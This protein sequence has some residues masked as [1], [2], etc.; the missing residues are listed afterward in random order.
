MDIIRLYQDYTIDFV[1]EGHKHARPGWVNVECPWCTGN[2]GYHLGYEL[3]K[4]YYYCWR[5]GWH[6][7]VPTVSRLLKIREAEGRELV[8]L[9]GLLIAKRIE[10]PAIKSKKEFQLP[11]YVDVLRESHKR[12]LESRGYDPE[13]LEQIWNLMSTSPLSTLDGISYRNRILIPFLWN[14]KMVSFDTRVTSNRLPH[15][16][17]YKA[18]PKSRE[19]IEHKHIL[20]GRQEEWRETGIC[21][22][23]P[24]DVWRLGTAS[25]ATSGIQYT[26]EQLIVM[27]RTF[28]RIFVMYDNEPQAQAQA[29]KLVADLNFR[30]VESAIVKI[31]TNDPG[32]L[33]QSD[34]DY[35]VKQLL[36]FS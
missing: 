25:F 15:E 34:A 7:I 17:R 22:E 5:C 12:Y 26:P 23:G 13:R 20:Y 29:K 11:L 28:K 21:V 1:T 24:T 9:Y 36:N 16:Y 6:P 3:D 31:A 35:I 30:G 4:D 2:P 33:P 18:C 19:L 27:A 14:Y 32:S 8:R 10:E